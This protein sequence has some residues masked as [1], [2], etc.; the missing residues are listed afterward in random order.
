[1]TPFSVPLW[2]WLSL[3]A[4]GFLAAIFWAFHDVRVERDAALAE[5]KNRFDTLRYALSVV[6]FQAH[7]SQNA[8]GKTWDVAVCV[9]I[10]NSS[11]EPLRYLVEELSTLIQGRESEEEESRVPRNSD[12]ITPEGH[13]T[14]SC[15]AV[16]GVPVPW[17]EAS[18]QLTVRY[19]HPQNRLRY[20]KS[21]AF[22]LVVPPRRFFGPLSPDVGLEAT[23][24]SNPEV[25]DLTDVPA[26]KARVN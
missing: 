1:M 7:V 5:I 4:G 8:D 16:R 18:L 14:V 12:V 26:V 6:R 20:Q 21:W 2:T 24:V 9:W 10:A 23:L 19:G 25:E 22:R 3:L 17:Q 13:V 11:V 15:P